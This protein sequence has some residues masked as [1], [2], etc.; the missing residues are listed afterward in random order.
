MPIVRYRI[1]VG[2]TVRVLERSIVD[3]EKTERFVECTVAE[4]RSTPHD[5]VSLIGPEGERRTYRLLSVEQGGSIP[6]AKLQE[7]RAQE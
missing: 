6:G 4:N 7:W 5:W 3:G 2:D 1:P